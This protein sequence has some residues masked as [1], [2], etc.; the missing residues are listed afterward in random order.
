MQATKT[1]SGLWHEAPVSHPNIS[2]IETR[3]SEMTTSSNLT[4]KLDVIHICMLYIHA[5]MM[6]T[7]IISRVPN[8][9]TYDPQITV[10]ETGDWYAFGDN[11][12]M[13]V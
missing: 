13:L 11:A 7:R 8:L 10:P 9:I 4:H 3:G 1:T 5:C 12:N 6:H 2:D